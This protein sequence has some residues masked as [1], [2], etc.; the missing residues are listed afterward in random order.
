MESSALGEIMRS[1]R[2]RFWG[3][4]LGVVGLVAW[5][6]CGGGDGAEA[7][8]LASDVAAPDVSYD[9]RDREGPAYNAGTMPD[10]A[11]PFSEQM[12]GAL[13]VQPAV[14]PYALPLD[15]GAVEN[16]AEIL[17]TPGLGLTLNDGARAYLAANG[18][19]MAEH[20]QFEQ[21]FDPYLHI[22]SQG[23]DEPPIL[24]TSDSLLHLYHLFFDQLLKYVEAHEFVP[25][26]TG[27][28]TALVDA[29]L[30]QVPLLDGAMADAARRNAAF[31][32]VAAKLVAPGYEVPGEVADVVAAE[33]ALIEA[34]E[35][36]AASPLF[37]Q[38]CPSWCDP[39]DP[40]SYR[41][42]TEAGYVCYCEDYTQ[43]VPRGHY[44]LSEDLKRYFRGMMWLGRLAFRI[45]VDVETRQA[46]LATD[47]LKG[48]SVELD[49][50]TVS[51]TDLWF[52]IYG[53]TAFFAGQAD[54]LTFV[55]YDQAVRA[56]FGEGFDLMALNDAATLASLQ[57]KLREL[58]QPKI[59]SSFLS[60][61]LDVT[62][63]TQGWRFL[64][65]RFAPDSY[66]LGQMVWNHVGPDLAYAGY[67]D[68][69][70]GCFNGAEPSC[71]GL[72]LDISNCICYA[73]L[74]SGPWGV[75]RLLPRGLDVM[76][77]LGDAT[78]DD[79]LTA[80]HRYCGFTDRL[81]DLKTEF[82][83]Y[84]PAD[85]VQNA[86]WGWL[87]ALKPL[88]GPFGEGWPTWMQA[89]AW[90]RKALNA[91]LTSWAELRHDTILYVKQSYTP[92]VEGT[93]VG[94]G[95]PVFAGYVEPLPAF[96]HR[97]AF[98]TRF[99]KDGLATRD[100]LPQGLAPL[101]DSMAELLD[102]LEAI[103]TKELAM[104]ALSEDQ[105]DLVRGIGTTFETLV[106]NLAAA[107]TV[108]VPSDDPWATDVETSAEGDGFKTTVVADVHTDGNTKNVLEEGSGKLDWLVIVQRTVEGRLVAS[109][110][111][112][113]TYYEFAHPMSD[114]LTDEAW[115]T[116]LNGADAPAR[117]TWIES[118]YGR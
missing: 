21:V 24:V 1:G 35:K 42:A 118:V 22:A 90:G 97:L 83:A 84:T 105:K 95:Q 15:L 60:A 44:T 40:A 39:C 28:T 25:M 20:G 30:Q 104:E 48:V 91:S 2:T 51:G 109:L 61:Y 19:V 26:L 113:F 31:F 72:D 7:D 99:T 112:V 70:R 69:V 73:G 81:A 58:R 101:M 114:R 54:D 68:A 8:A 82:A 17:A 59:L 71:D 43:Y 34:H 92:G 29:S 106:M 14:P 16:L 12:E 110:G 102:G 3:A 76:A 66:V 80:D 50:A 13:S 49:G 52:R 11:A 77:V 33:L 67:E 18:L 117:P 36:L 98:L 23:F 94:P 93:S 115:R 27:L 108:E 89:P 107:V 87:H 74:D 96:Y 47:A 53:V 79:V 86:Y 88:F 62:D 85:W 116:L 32:A 65:Q 41:E 100:A 111:P 6:G 38:D 55:E 64:G 37:N 4:V 78:A 46:V 10:T 75:C 9:V 63:E 45:K 103:A 5:T 56:L 57:E